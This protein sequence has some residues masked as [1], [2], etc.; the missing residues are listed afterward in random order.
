MAVK[1]IK[2][3]PEIE[4]A[5]QVEQ[6]A[7]QPRKNTGLWI[8]GII[9]VLAAVGLWLYKTKNFPVVAMVGMRPIFR[10]EVNKELFKQGGKSMVDNL[11]T[12]RIVKD[13][14]AKEGI[15]ITDAQINQKIDEVKQ[16]LGPGQDLNTLLAERGMTLN[17]VKNQLRLQMGVEKAVSDK[18]TVS[19]DEVAA[20][21]K[22]N[23]A[24][25]TATTEAEKTVEATTAIK[26]QKMQRAVSDWVQ[27]LRTKAKVWYSDINLKTQ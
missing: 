26:Q 2:R 25:L 13:E 24:V 19:G 5:L 3:E 4:P 16:N 11:V 12:E 20:Y 15:V 14:L 21:I 18:A 17:D 9:V 22:T 7:P 27:G 6:L 8:V 1:R 10:Y 23:A